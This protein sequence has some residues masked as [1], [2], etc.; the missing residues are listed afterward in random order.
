MRS[1]SAPLPDVRHIAV[2]RPNA[3]G[4]FVFA[5][6][7]LHALKA[8]Y[9]EARITYLGK[10]W[11]ADFLAGR[12]GPVDE[13]V[14]VPPCPG[15]GAPA[16][17][18]LSD[19]ARRFVDAMRDAR[20][21]LALQVYGGGRHSNPLVRRFEPRCAI[22]LQAPDAPPLD[23]WVRYGELQNRR[24]QMLEVAALV[25]ADRLHL[26][27][28]LRVT[29]RDREE[30]WHVLP[31]SGAP[32]VIIQPGASDPRRR[33]PARRFAA[34]A[35]ALAARGA[36]VAVNGTPQEG[37]VVRAVLEAMRRPALDLTG[38]LSLS[39][40]CGLLE[41]A[42]LLVSND[43]GPLH[44]GLAVGTPCVGIYWLTNL[45]ESGPLRQH[46]HRPALS[47]RIHCPVCGMENLRERCA[48]D[49]SFVAG[50]PL[51]EVMAHAL[52]LFEARETAGTNGIGEYRAA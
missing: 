11:H 45:I 37:P 19:Q 46:G 39:G 33:W 29:E 22:G 20:F 42:A 9:P 8:A 47:V 50:V 14:V 41:R 10:P 21:D 31:A 44:L 48:H 13:V 7:C 6:P 30:A 16:D 25:G 28:E 12:P 36:M 15:V 26:A 52:D 1:P 43:T 49:D 38:R 23:R 34:V 51:E 35:D 18:P 24:L 5:L 40:L 32:L 27:Q 3:V 2:L 4:D 17:A